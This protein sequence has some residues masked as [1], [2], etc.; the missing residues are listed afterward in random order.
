MIVQTQKHAFLL[1]VSIPAEGFAV[2]NGQSA[3]W[4]VMLH[5]AF[6]HKVCREI[7]LFAA[8]KWVVCKM[9]TVANLRDVTI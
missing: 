2:A 8:Q 9:R 7:P 5:I 3:R 4:R 6:A 1:N